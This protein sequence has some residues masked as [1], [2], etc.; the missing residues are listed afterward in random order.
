MDVSNNTSVENPSSNSGLHRS[1]SRR[2]HT[3][4]TFNK[5]FFVL[6][7]SFLPGINYFFLAYW[8]FLQNKSYSLRNFSRAAM[9]WVTLI[10][11]VLAFGWLYLAPEWDQ[12][13]SCLKSASTKDVLPEQLIFPEIP[14]DSIQ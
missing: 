8:A 3:S 6:L 2:E 13:V 7:L 12:F 11:A 1:H 14:K 4:L 9:L 10:L 5:W